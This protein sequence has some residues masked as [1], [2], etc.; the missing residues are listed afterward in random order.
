LSHRTEV[1]GTSAADPRT[2][3]TGLGAASAL[4]KSEW[5]TMDEA[6]CKKLEALK[7]T[8]TSRYSPAVEIMQ[9]LPIPGLPQR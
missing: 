7:I 3:S 2:E 4:E 6:K 5:N 8:H 1:H 9:C